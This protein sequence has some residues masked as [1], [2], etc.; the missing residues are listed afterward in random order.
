MKRIVFGWL[1][2]GLLAACTPKSIVLDDTFTASDAD[3]QAV[4]AEVAQPT[5]V[6]V[7]TGTARASW[8]GPQGN[9]RGV[10][11]FS[12]DRTRTYLSLRNNLGIEGY[13]IG[14]DAD[15]VTIYDRINR[16]AVRLAAAEADE[17]SGGVLPSFPLFRVLLPDWSTTRIRRLYESPDAWYFLFQD[18]RTAVFAK[19]DGRI[20]RLEFPERE[21]AIWATYLFDDHT[22]TR[23]V[24]LPAKV[25]VLSRDRKSNIFLHLQSVQIDPADAQFDLRIP[26]GVRIERP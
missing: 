14:L 5:Q 1:M 20:R 25:Q 2:M 3:P 16:T 22:T 17:R 6:R 4:F 18:A 13:R 11:V 24:R 23:G 7:L 12:A 9:D 8:S 26:S 10:V 15:S 19:T 21:A